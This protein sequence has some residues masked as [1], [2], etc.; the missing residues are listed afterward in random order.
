MSTPLNWLRGKL[1]AWLGVPV[2]AQDTSKKDEPQHI[3]IHPSLMAQTLVK[4]G[5]QYITYRKVAPPVL[6]DNVRGAFVYDATK[7][8]GRLGPPVL[9]MDDAQ[10]AP[11][12]AYLNQA[13][14]GMGFPGYGYLS[15]LS[16]RSE[17]RAPVET[18]AS[19]MT[20][21]FIDVTVKG[22]AS[23]KKREKR[24][25]Q[26]AEDE[27]LD[28]GLED[29]LEQM[30]TAIDEFKIRDHFR[31]IAEHDG[32]FGRGQLFIDVDTGSANPDDIRQLPLI[33]SPETI[34]RGSLKGFKVVEPIWTTPY[35]YNSTDPTRGDFYKPSA[36]FMIGKR[37]HASRL[38][39]FV[40]REVPD[41][42]KPAYNFS[43]LSMS[44]LMEPY[45]FQWLRTR[46]SVSDLVHNFSVMVLKTDMNAVLQGGAGG[47]EAGTGLLDRGKLFVNTRDNQGLTMIDKNREELVE[48]HASLAGL[49][50][51]Q[52]QSQEHMA[53]PSHMPLVKLT[54]ITPAGLNA[55]SEGEIQVWYDWIRADQIFFYGPHLKHVLDILQL[56]LFGEIE[57][58]ISF[59]FV[60]LKTPTV[61]ELAEIRKSNA[62]TD[63]I[64][65]DKGVVSPDEVRE[66][67]AADPDSGY[68]NLSGDAPGPPEAELM[69]QEHA[70]GQEGAEADHARGKE[71]ATVQA[72]L[73]PALAKTGKG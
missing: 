8:P 57:P 39:T 34:K 41:I 24:G 11:A 54:G 28:E 21:E 69:Q 17:Y 29:K 16:Q 7:D 38:L 58:A 51:L 42:L 64:Y 52:A 40:S 67:V 13:N 12:W 62:E 3:K 71:M 35:A 23:K 4:A 68:N 27:A 44:Q 31:Q 66:R 50:K 26:V 55:D 32:F 30:E 48:V 45:V 43:G 36:W 47:A 15:E 6:P 70:L 2:G 53:A 1:R 49:D 60:P 25:E 10:T 18:I 73:K 72:K 65:I 33:V 22:K 9:A 56:H 59:T 61:K 5:E 63:G 46:N 19:E 14:C 37:V 20:R